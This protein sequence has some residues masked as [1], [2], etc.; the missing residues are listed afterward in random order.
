[1]STRRVAAVG[2]GALAA[3]SAFGC[4]R[5]PG[6]ADSASSTV[7]GDSSR[8][9]GS[10]G[11]ESSS[12]APAP[13]GATPPAR[14]PAS[15]ATP[16]D[17]SVRPSGAPV[18]PA[19]GADTVRGVVAVVGST[20]DE[21]VVVRPNGGG[22]A[23]TALGPQ[24]AALGRLSGA[25]VWI[26]GTPAPMRGFTVTRF[27]VRSV[28]GAAAIDGT[29]ARRGAGYVI[30]TTASGAERAV[31]KPPAALVTHV[32]ARVWVTGSLETGALAFGVISER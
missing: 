23:V 28:D 29:L 21:H 13:A 32:G 20:V 10:V 25:D 11:A 22:P 31:A 8:A 3:V 5:A 16:A 26:A 18:P 9:G 27:L 6:R 14:L 7:G 1:M 12:L 4:G 30:V 24:A 15:S 2:L 19:A 17:H